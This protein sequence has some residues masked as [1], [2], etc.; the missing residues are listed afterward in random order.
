MGTSWSSIVTADINVDN[1][2]LSV[3][4]CYCINLERPKKQI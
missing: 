2:I 4:L 3:K 1:A